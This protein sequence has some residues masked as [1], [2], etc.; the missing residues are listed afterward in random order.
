[1]LNSP[2]RL[3]PDLELGSYLFELWLAGNGW[4]RRRV[5][6]VDFLGA[7]SLRRS[8]SVD[9]E[10]P[11]TD[12]VTHGPLPVPLALLERRPLVDF[13]VVDEA[14]SALPVCTR[15]ENRFA[16]W[17]MLAAVAAAEIA[18][19]DGKGRGLSIEPLYED[20]RT[21]AFGDSKVAL[22]VLEGL[23]ESGDELNRTLA[24][25]SFFDA[26][27]RTLATVF[28]LLVPIE[29]SPGQRRV[30]KFRYT[31][32]LAR[33]GSGPE[34]FFQA[35]GWMPARFAFY[36]PEVGES[37]SYHFELAA[38]QDLEV[39]RSILQLTDPVTG[40]EDIEGVSTGSR[41]HLYTTGKE[42]DVD[43]TALVWLQISRTGL[44]RSGC[45]VAGMIC[46]VLLFFYASGRL[47]RPPRDI[48]SA[49][50]LTLP[51]L[52]ATLVVRPGEHGLVTELL[53]GVRS[54]VALSGAVA[55][56][57]ALLLGT[58]TSGEVLLGVMESTARAQR[59]LLRIP[60]PGILSL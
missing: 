10:I 25:S 15:A 24:E 1:M 51:A 14:G 55:Y 2:D 18:D 50:L 16:A 41:A 28:L 5:E 30:V 23:A 34:R 37:E 53:L 47:D 59:S 43:G 38:P 56:T 42:P 39:S 52:V 44:L 4:V 58:G 7:G 57:A 29:G 40:R 48:Q 8:V 26:V 3:E 27:A 35:M 9:F 45:V 31:L 60:I 22:Q 32:G 46:A 17:S 19:A 12:F 33:R 13:D 54:A 6:T 20:L 36:V 49:I 11:E 21:I